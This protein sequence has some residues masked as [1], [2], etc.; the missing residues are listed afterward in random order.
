MKNIDI[1]DLSRKDWRKLTHILG[2]NLPSSRVF[3]VSAEDIK[4]KYLAD[5]GEYKDG[6]PFNV[7]ELKGFKIHCCN[8]TP[9]ARWW[10]QDNGE[11]LIGYIQSPSENNDKNFT[12]KLLSNI[13]EAYKECGVSKINLKAG[14]KV[15][16]YFWA[17]CGAIPTKESWHRL[18]IEIRKKLPE[19]I[20]DKTVYQNSAAIK[21][22][23]EVLKSDDP[24]KIWAIAD[25]E[26]GKDL[27]LNEHNNK[28]ERIHLPNTT[29]FGSINLEDKESAKRLYSYLHKESYADRITKQRKNQSSFHRYS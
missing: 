6:N 20:N 23:G 21:M 7:Y 8:N 26:I 2:K 14:Y 12:R 15:G 1:N 19:I 13:V 4:N 10:I 5:D 24:R 25:S 22:V 11:G 9:C 3:E 29:W 28:L 18:K 16:A 27:L 17:K